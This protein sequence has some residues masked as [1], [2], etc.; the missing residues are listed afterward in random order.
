MEALAEILAALAE[1]IAD[2][3][4]SALADSYD[5]EAERRALLKAQRNLSDYRMA[6]ALKK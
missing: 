6:Q 5:P 4:K 3:I 2:L 1:P